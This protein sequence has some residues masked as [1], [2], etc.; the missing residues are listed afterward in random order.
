MLIT[1]FGQ[2]KFYNPLDTS[3]P[4]QYRHHLAPEIIQRLSPQF[5]TDIY[6]FGL[7]LYRICGYDLFYNQLAK[8]YDDDDNFNESKFIDDVLNSRFPDRN[9]FH[10]FVPKELRK[11]INKCLEINL[12]DRY[13]NI[14][15]IMSDINTKIKDFEV[16]E[17]QSH[18]L[19]YIKQ[20]GTNYELE[21]SDNQN[22][23]D[24]CDIKVYKVTSSTRPTKYEETIVK[25]KLFNKIWKIIVSLRRGTL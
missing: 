8:Y 14:S 18:Q 25:S 4:G 22:D 16:V 9:L 15:E 5:Q 13:H 17:S 11:I 1:D 2:S 19:I 6:H 24:K 12:Q 7:T 3:I 20:N 10:N 23:T 21:I